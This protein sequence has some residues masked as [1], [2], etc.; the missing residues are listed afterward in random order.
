MPLVL[1]AVGSAH[2]QSRSAATVLSVASVDANG[3]GLVG[4]GGAGAS[5]NNLT[6]DLNNVLNTPGFDDES[7]AL[8]E[9]RALY[10]FCDAQTGTGA[11]GWTGDTAAIAPNANVDQAAT[12]APEELF[13]GMDN[14]RAA[15]NGQTAN[16]ARRLS[17][18]RLAARHSDRA[19]SETLAKRIQPGAA[20]LAGE[21]GERGATGPIGLGSSDRANDLLLALQTGINAGDETGNS[22]LGF[23]LNGRANIVSSDENKAERGSN[24]TGGGFTLGVDKQLRDDAYA[25]VAFGYTRIDTRYDSS[26]SRSDLDAVAFSFYGSWYPTDNFTVDG[27]VSTAW[28]GLD[29]K[30]QIVIADGGPPSRDLDGSTDGAT[31]GFDVGGGY[32]VPI[33]RFTKNEDLAGLSFEPYLRLN[34]LYTWIDGY[35]QKGGDNSLNLAINSQDATSVTSSLG[36]NTEYT[37]STRVGVLT[38]SARVAYVH[39]FNNQNDNVSASLAAI[40]GSNFKLQAISADRDYADIGVSLAATLGQGFSEFVDYDVIAGNSNFTIHQITAGIRLEY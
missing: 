28:L 29:T 37:W 2:A 20:G 8:P 21:L 32:T 23:F 40:P 11:N 17:I 25:G 33:T 38:S 27:S 24:S 30:N 19:G 39:E 16:V 7:V 4:C 12:L 26:G 9:R 10:R 31:F 18:L 6:N 35:R 14:A 13:I 5:G 36:L 15:F 22:G 34:L 1:L 3:N